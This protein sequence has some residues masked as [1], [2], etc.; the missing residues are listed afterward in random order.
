VPALV[1]G[2]KGYV[3]FKTMPGINELRLM[4]IDAKT[5]LQ[6]PKQ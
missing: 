5:R 6:I 3:P 4:M 1:I 2:D